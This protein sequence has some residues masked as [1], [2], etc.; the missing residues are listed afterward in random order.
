MGV[1]HDPAADAPWVVTVSSAADAGWIRVAAS[2][3]AAKKVRMRVMCFS[4]F[5]NKRAR[6]AYTRT[7]RRQAMDYFSENGIG[8]IYCFGMKSP[9]TC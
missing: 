9:F 1:G 3:E 5:S 2:Q 7:P 8:T 4:S 6:A